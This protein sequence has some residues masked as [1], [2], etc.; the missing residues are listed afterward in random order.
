MNGTDL[1]PRSGSCSASI[2]A[3][4]QGPSSSCSPALGHVVN[5]DSTTNST[6]VHQPSDS[7]NES[8]MGEF[9]HAVMSTLQYTLQNSFIVVFSFVFSLVFFNFR[10]KIT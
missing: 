10:Q 5:G 3:D 4:G 7:D 8:R 2:G 6:P 1:G 9:A